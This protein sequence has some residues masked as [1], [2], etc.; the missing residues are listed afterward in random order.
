LQSSAEPP[1]PSPRIKAADFKALDRPERTACA[2]CG[3]AWSDYVERKKPGG[4]P[5]RRICR[6]CY[7]GARKRAQKSTF[8]LPGTFDVSRAEP[9]K[10]SVGRCTICNLDRAAYL[11]RATGTSL[12]E[13]CYQR[14]V[15]DQGRGEVIG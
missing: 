12:C 10:A 15:R 5:P 14:A 11:D 3:R 13:Y 2:V 8:I 9:L 4:D 6:T 1:G 7:L